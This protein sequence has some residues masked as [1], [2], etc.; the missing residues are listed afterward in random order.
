MT[1]VKTKYLPAAWLDEVC[2]EPVD[3]PDDLLRVIDGRTF[4]VA[5]DEDEDD[6]WKTEVVNGEFV[7]FCAFRD[8]GH[9]T[10]SVERDADGRLVWSGGEG[11]PAE[12]NCFHADGDTNTLADSLDQ[13]FA[14]MQLSDP[15][16]SG[17]FSVHAYHWSDGEDW[18]FAID[19]DGCGH[20]AE[21]GTFGEEAVH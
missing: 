3:H 17:E 12:A 1:D 2:P 6:A 18:Y 11:I 7:T 13:M 10:L 9:W 15:D 20:F 19:D 21:P 4:L 8:H 16:L 5:C 14:N